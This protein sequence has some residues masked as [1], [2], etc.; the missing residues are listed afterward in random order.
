MREKDRTAPLKFCERMTTLMMRPF[1]LFTVEL[2]TPLKTK[3]SATLM[4]T[5]SP[6]SNWKSESRS[7]MR[8]TSCCGNCWNNNG[9][10]RSGSLTGGVFC[11]PADMHVTKHTRL[12]RP[13][14]VVFI[15]YVLNKKIVAVILL[16]SE[17]WYGI[18]I[19]GNYR[20]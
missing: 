1:S 7:G 9:L 6:V 2:T 5:S 19:I 13:F 16:S 3:L 10:L 12:V 8:Q 11:A 15:G 17:G 20:Y 4:L 18:A 14:R